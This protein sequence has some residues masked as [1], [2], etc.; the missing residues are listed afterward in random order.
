M[1]WGLD[2]S[3]VGTPPQTKLTSFVSP[4]VILR[5]N[6]KSMEWLDDVINHCESNLKSHPASL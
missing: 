4:V 2:D 5:Q 6:I 1:F 3:A